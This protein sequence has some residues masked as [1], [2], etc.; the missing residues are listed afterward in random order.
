MINVNFVFMLECASKNCHTFI[1]ECVLGPPICHECMHNF[2][3][4]L[5]PCIA[6]IA[7]LN[8]TCVG[9][10]LERCHGNKAHN[11]GFTAS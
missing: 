4:L 8:G 9:T 7:F 3:A 1:N 10:L 2:F 11:I 5:P 6:F